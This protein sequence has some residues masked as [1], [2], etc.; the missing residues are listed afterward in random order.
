MEN[1]SQKNIKTGKKPTSPWSPSAPSKPHPF[2]IK[3]SPLSGKY[4]A[5]TF[6]YTFYF[7]WGLLK[8]VEEMCFDDGFKSNQLTDYFFL[9]FLSFFCEEELAWGVERDIISVNL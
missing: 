5:W 9:F 3:I 7:L 1:V 4:A 8:V 2:T 6:Y